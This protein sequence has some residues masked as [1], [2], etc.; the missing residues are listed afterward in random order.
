[1]LFCFQPRNI[2][3]FQVHPILSPALFG[4]TICQ[5]PTTRPLAEEPIAVLSECS[6][7]CIK[8]TI[9][10]FSGHVYCVSSRSPV[11]RSFISCASSTFCLS[12]EMSCAPAAILQPPKAQLIYIPVNP[13]TCRSN[14][15][16]NRSIF[17]MCPRKAC[18]LCGGT[19]L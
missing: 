15:S 8:T 2:F 5:P 16:I 18:Y 7:F 12:S 11:K 14:E 9:I 3:F 10:S 1:M 6:L 17:I 4:L 19:R 13:A